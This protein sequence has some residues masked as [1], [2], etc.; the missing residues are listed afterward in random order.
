MGRICFYLPSPTLLHPHVFPHTLRCLYI[1]VTKIPINF[2][3]NISNRKSDFFFLF[4]YFSLSFC[5]KNSSSQ[6]ASR[7]ILE[8]QGH[9]VPE[10]S[11]WIIFHTNRIPNV[12]A[13][14][15]PCFESSLANFF[16][17]KRSTGDCK[18]FLNNFCSL[19][20]PS[21]IKILLYC[22][23]PVTGCMSICK[24]DDKKW[25]RLQGTF[26]LIFRGTSVF[27]CWKVTCFSSVM[28]IRQIYFST[29]NLTAA[30]FELVMMRLKDIFIPS[31][32]LTELSTENCQDMT[33]WKRWH[34]PFICRVYTVIN[35]H[36]S[37][38]YKK[39]SLLI[40]FVFV[41]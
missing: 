27:L 32:Q 16:I 2:L 20:V 1:F 7:F 4:L 35:I 22:I 40:C 26:G 36:A 19:V 3:L 18:F 31:G 37:T 11:R 34:L 33:T 30:T 41:D 38:I 21:G 24:R 15:C 17:K 13:V 39:K 29:K 6:K 23:I 28:L 25:I 12:G 14:F 8:A 5:Q 9:R 10:C